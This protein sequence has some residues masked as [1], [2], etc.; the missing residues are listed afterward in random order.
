MIKSYSKLFSLLSYIM[1]LLRLL[2]TFFHTLPP[3]EKKK[4]HK[5]LT[6]LKKTNRKKNITKRKRTLKGGKSGF[7][8]K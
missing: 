4:L 3:K 8:C 6:K 2:D 1:N 7:G 5:C